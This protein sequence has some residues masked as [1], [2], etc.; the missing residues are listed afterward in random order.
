MKTL[1]I[2]SHPDIKTSTTQAFLRDAQKNLKQVTWHPLDVLYSN[3]QIQIEK[4]QQLLTQF[5]RIIFQ[6]PMYWYSSP[7]LLKKWED[8]VLT[9][10]FV[11]L[12]E[13]ASLKGK[14][15]GIV[16][17]LGMPLREYQRGGVENFSISEMLIPYQ[18]LAKR[19][20][21]KF[22]KP[23]VISQFAYMTNQKRAKCLIDYQNYITNPKYD[24]FA[25]YEKWMIQ[26]L[27]EF[28]QT[29]PDDKQLIF[30]TVIDQIQNNADQLA[31]LNWE[32]NMMKKKEGY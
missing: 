31:E 7:A 24:H 1:V 6:F 32:V 21:M 10:N 17:S 12:S 30:Q 16:T 11:Y 23:F 5:D 4:E 27:N 14:E 9:R 20:G 3:Y 25:N 2:I 13:Q 22:L 26:Q 29:L 18:A 28:K 15:L 8:D 19:A